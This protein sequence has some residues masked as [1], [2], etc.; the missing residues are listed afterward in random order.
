MIPQKLGEERLAAI[1]RM[2]GRQTQVGP[3]AKRRK[4]SKSP[5]RRQKACRVNKGIMI[6]NT[7]AEAL[8]FD[9]K[10][11]NHKWDD[12]MF[13]EVQTQIDLRT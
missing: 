3:K 10:N 8:E 11:G 12:A 1:R 6:P 13:E 9:K 2:A 5:N 7:I 4:K